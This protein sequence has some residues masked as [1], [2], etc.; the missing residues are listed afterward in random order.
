MRSLYAAVCGVV[1]S[2]GA[3]GLARAQAPKAAAAP[4]DTSLVGAERAI[5]ELLKRQQWNAFDDAIAGETLVES[6][7]ISIAKRG[8]S[9]T[10]LRG[11]VTKSY[12]L[13]DATVRMVTP[14]VAI[15]TY[16]ASVDQTF[17][18]QRTPSPFYMM[19]VWQRK[20]GKWSPVAHAETAAA[21][22]K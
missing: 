14:D 15:V 8:T 9:A 16:K 4:A 17:N 5:W 3:A 7:G 12:T 11:L 6:G 19:S 20:A 2:L 13:E 1:V 18:G 10:A 22:A 21:N